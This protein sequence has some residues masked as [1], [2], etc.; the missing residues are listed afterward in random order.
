MAQPWHGPARTNGQRA[1]GVEPDGHSGQ[2]AGH[3][4]GRVR[5]RA[6]AQRLHRQ[7]SA[8][9]RPRADA[10]TQPPAP[11]H[12]AVQLRARR[13]L[14]GAVRQERLLAVQ[15]PRGGQAEAQG[16]QRPGPHHQQRELHPIGRLPHRL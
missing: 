2:L 3:G 13:G 5:D 15:H 8:R 12:P 16:V 6:W 1:P 14:P 10:R 7:G 9:R 4:L 11:R